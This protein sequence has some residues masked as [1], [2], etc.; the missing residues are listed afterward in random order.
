MRK[1]LPFL[2]LHCALCIIN[3]AFS[4]PGEWTWMHGSN[5][6]NTFGNFGVQGVSSPSNVPP[7]MYETCEFKDINGNF[8]LYG[9]VGGGTHNDLWKYDP[10]INEWTWM[11][12]NNSPGD[13]GVFG[14][15]GVPSSTNRPPCLGYGTASWTDLNGN[16]WLLGGYSA[17]DMNCLWKYD[18][19]TNEWTW[20]HGANV[21]YQAG[22]YGTQGVPSVLNTPGARQESAGAWTDNA[23]DL[24][25]FGGYTNGGNLNDL[26][27]Y[28]IATDEWTWMKGSQLPL[29]TG[30]YG[31][32]GIEDP[33]NTPGA[34]QVYSRW[35]DG[36][37]NLWLFSGGDYLSSTFFND[38][39]R[40]NPLTNN[41]TW[42]NGSNVSN[43]TGN[44]GIQCQPSPT[45]V[46]EPR[47]E[48]RG[49]CTD[50]NGNFWMFGGGKGG[51]TIPQVWNDLWMY[52]PATNQ[53]TWMDGDTTYNPTG[54]WGTMGVTSPT[55]KPNGRSGN[56]LWSDNSGHL[57]S[58]GGS[59]NNYNTPFQDIWKYNIDPSCA[60]CNTLPVALFSAPNHIC[61]GT[62]TDFNNISINATSYLWSFAGATP[63][64]STDVDPQ[65][66][67]YNTPGTYSVS[68][69]ATNANG[70]D[71]LTLNNFITVYPYPAPQGI[72]QSGD[73]LFANAGAVSYQWYF[74][75]NIIPGATNYFYVAMQSG[76][77]NV[78]ATD[79][80]NCEVEAAIFDVI[81]GIS[82][83]SF[84]EVS[85]LRLFPNP[86]DQ[87]LM[88]SSRYEEAI[89]EI[90]IFNLLGELVYAVQPQT[91][92]PG[93]S[94]LTLETGID[95][96]V[97]ISGL[98]WIEATSGD[99]VFR[100]KFVKE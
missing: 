91:T 64:T 88:V 27:R 10:V 86:V 65:N 49:A 5:V 51:G 16:F 50:A 1:S 15:L 97:L 44:Y 48:S 98:Y 42:M 31:S 34:R 21:S 25:L 66:I 75:G 24:W 89:T 61:P 23:G 58:F 100:G 46:P 73:T 9:G 19:G 11:K 60:L 68:L 56:L 84:D 8:W 6:S 62:C 87:F 69:I 99:R 59:T 4:Q 29:Q 72:A 94:A 40:Y 37:G 57:Y 71:T 14:T 90:L 39:W 63:S 95:V 43:S 20:M 32:Q 83:H 47:F 7:A 67:C 35:K 45:N 78:V 96:H 2:L 12:G 79:A 33:T 53:W 76:D 41:W 77:Y 38:M 74:G 36:A 22:I 55:N 70:S 54:N 18:V 13:P 52:C 92:S 3:S 93:L 82:P 30:I 17:G 85:G 80:N 26:W 81:A 28:H